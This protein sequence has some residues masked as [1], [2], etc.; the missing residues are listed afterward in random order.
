MI[1]EIVKDT[2]ILTQ[3]SEKFVVGQDE[4]LIQ[5]MQGDKY[6]PYRNPS[7]IGKS[8]KTYTAEE[9]CLSL[10]GKRTVRR[11]KQIKLL[12]VDKN[13]KSKMQVFSGF[14]AQIIQHECDH[15]N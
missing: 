7:I 1:R 2:E 3:K 13:G 15:L 10:E 8:P 12:Y 9:T 4:P 14:V 6:V 5:D 11:Y